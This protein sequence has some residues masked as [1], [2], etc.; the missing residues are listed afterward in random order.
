MAG[1]SLD[2]AVLVDSACDTQS[3]NEAGLFTH[4]A[5][6]EFVADNDVSCA[7]ADSIL[8]QLELSSGIS[9]EAILLAIEPQ[10]VSRLVRR[11]VLR[12]RKGV[13]TA[14]GRNARRL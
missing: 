3:T 8:D 14:S 9:A 12:D 2:V 1:Q 10:P 4:Y 11:R 5:Q 7:Q 13:I 6:V